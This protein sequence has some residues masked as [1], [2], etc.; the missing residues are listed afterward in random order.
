MA[1]YTSNIIAT[2]T[3][4]DLPDPLHASATVE[5]LTNLAFKAFDGDNATHWYCYPGVTGELTPNFGVNKRVARYAIY[6]ANN[7]DS[8]NPTAWKFY[9]SANGS[10]WTELDSRTGIT[11]TDSTMQNFDIA[12]PG[13]Y[14]YYKIAMSAA[15]STPN[16]FTIKT[17]E[18]YE[19]ILP[20]S[21]FFALL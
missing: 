1:D 2:M 5:Y 8:V 3:S 16:G 11:W 14:Q 12:S 6:P 7:T 13:T 4:N 17:L 20:S 21:G 15:Q 19:Q 10:S 18:M 9:G